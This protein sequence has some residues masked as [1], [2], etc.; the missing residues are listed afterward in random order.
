M[1]EPV[2]IVAE[3]GVFLGVFEAPDWNLAHVTM[4]RRLR[5]EV[6]RLRARVK[7]SSKWNTTGDS[8]D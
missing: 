7:E 5:D 8:G 3:A 4:V 1:S 2:D 6:E